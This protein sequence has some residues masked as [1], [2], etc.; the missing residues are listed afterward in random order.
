GR[1][2]IDHALEL[3]AAVR[4]QLWSEGLACSICVVSR[5]SVIREKAEKL[6]MTAIDNPN[7]EEGISATIRLGT[8]YML[9]QGASRFVYL[10]ADQPELTAKTVVWLIRQAIASPLGVTVPAAGARLGN[11]CIFSGLYADLL[12]GLQGEQGGKLIIREHMNDCQTMA[13]EERELFDIDKKEQ[14]DTIF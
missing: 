3:T 2:L 6:R 7:S 13:V 4:R 14:I 10:V 12:L 11:P 9:E 1:P 8:T 5:Q